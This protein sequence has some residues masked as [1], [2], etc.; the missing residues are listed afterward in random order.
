MIKGIDVSSWQGN[1]DFAKVKASGIDFVIIRAGYGREVSQIDKCFVQNYNAAKVAGLD[2]GAYW[3]SYADSA[4]DAVKE[5][6]ACM[7]VIKGKKFE[8]PIYFDLEEQSQ[9]AK[10]RNFC[11]SIIK[12]FC[13]ELEKNGYLAGLYCSTYYLNNYISNSVA[14]K[15]ALWVAQYN[16]RCTYT[17]NKYGIWQYS[18]E[19]RIN[20]ISGNVDMDYCYTDYPAIVKNGGY[21]G[22]KKTTAKKIAANEK[23]TT[24]TATTTAKKKTVDEL[25]KEVIAGK[26]AAGDE[27]KQKLTAA[28]YDYSK[29]QAKVNELMA[30]P[31][32]KSVDEI[33]KEVIKGKW[34]SGDERKAKLT[35]AGYD[36]G[37]VQARVNELM[38][39]Q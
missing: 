18:S 20:G 10:G 27:R 9:F 1:I 14:G 35:S 21:N 11:D 19:G 7:E 28:G 31:A 8:Y 15:Y 24:S 38:K 12:A 25:A 5:A 32:L 23:K 3:Y 2:V 29:V 39:N 26:W 30:K 6:K 34:S 4:E 33:A 22:Y 13:G 37:K 16:Y 36:Y 17:A